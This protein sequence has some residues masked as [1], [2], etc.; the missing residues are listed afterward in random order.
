MVN[1]TIGDQT[2]DLNPNCHLCSQL[3][4]SFSSVRTDGKVT[5]PTSLLDP[6]KMWLRHDMVI[7]D[8]ESV[9]TDCMNT[10]FGPASVNMSPYL[11]TQCFISHGETVTT[12]ITHYLHINDDTV[13]IKDDQCSALLPRAHL[14]Q[15]VL[16][17]IVIEVSSGEHVECALHLLLALMKNNY[18]FRFRRLTPVSLALAH[19]A[20]D[21]SLAFHVISV[22]H[23]FQYSG[24][25]KGT[26]VIEHPLEGM[27]DLLMV[28]PP[29]YQGMIKCKMSSVGI[30]ERNQ[31][32]RLPFRVLV[33]IV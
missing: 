12:F 5:L 17:D 25:M 13:Y 24:N 32:S 4:Q 22:P 16:G 19:V 27:R 33:T 31:M 10:G 26:L 23:I 21:H 29:R 28:K 1:V 8:D 15:H 11:V 6:F 9:L 14:V 7:V 18:R 3:Y 2:F 20:L 30:S